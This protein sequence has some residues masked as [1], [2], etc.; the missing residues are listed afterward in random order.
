VLISLAAEGRAMSETR[1][2][3]AI[4]VADVVG[5][6]RLAGADEDRTL[7]RLRGL[8]SDLI[9]PAIAA[10]HGRIV[11]RT[12]DG[13]LVEFRSVVDAVRCWA[14]V[15]QTRFTKEA[16]EAA[17]AL[18][19]Q[20]LKID[21]SNADALA[22]DAYTYAIEYILWRNPE[23]DYDAKI[24]G[25]TDQAIAIAPD[26]L[27]AYSAKG[28]YLQYSRRA[29]KAIDA[30]DAGLAVNP[31]Y[32]RLWSM[33]GDA[34]VFGGH[35]E[36]AKSDILRALRFSPRDPR[37]GTWTMF[38]GDADLALGHLDTAIED[39]HKAIDLGGAQAAYLSLA[40][41][42]A[43]A[44]KMD[45]AKIALAEARRLFPKLTVKWL[46]DQVWEPSIPNLSDGLRKA[47]LPEE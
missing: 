46:A 15:R 20:A 24:L 3:A 44:G 18:F 47:G 13:S 27:S 5:Y 23:T 22:G 7:S 30:A 39:S 41:A 26:A 40:A 21:P 43:L 2:I 33:R 8:R 6:S 25:P 32:A 29:D 35:F 31:N 10:H 4:L 1:K 11:K 12:G 45:E 42:S 9:D 38:L 19:E 34:N 37:S 28:V 16:N 17:R 36:Q 14:L